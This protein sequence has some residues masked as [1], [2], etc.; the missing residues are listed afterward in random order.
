MLMFSKNCSAISCWECFEGKGTWGGS[1]LHLA[2]KR[3]SKGRLLAYHMG[4][5]SGEEPNKLSTGFSS[6]VLVAG[7]GGRDGRWS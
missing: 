1:K 3:N 2:V 7:I 5:V 4:E 6:V